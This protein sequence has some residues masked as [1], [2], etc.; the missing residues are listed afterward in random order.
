MDTVKV[1]ATLDGET[2]DFE[3]KGGQTILEAAIEAGVDAPYACMA[4]TCTAC[5]A[6]LVEGTVEMEC[7]EALTDEEVEEGR[8]LTCQAVPTSSQ[9]VITYPD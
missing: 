4:G 3:C 7:Q 6:Q 1:K 2:F 8:I 5:E 9:I